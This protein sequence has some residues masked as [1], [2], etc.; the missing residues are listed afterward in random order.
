MKIIDLGLSQ[1]V[2]KH[3]RLK[4]ERG[5]IYYLAPEMIKQNYDHKVDIW[6]A[7]V[8]FYILVTGK[9]PFDGAV[10]APNGNV[11]LDSKQIKQKILEGR[12]NYKRRAFTLVNPG[13]LEIIQKMLTYDPEL[14]PEAREILKHPYFQKKINPQVR[15][16]GS[17]IC[18]V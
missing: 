8:I 18:L 13:V 7:G 2:G 9:P 10:K 1:I 14:R 16:K 17:W 6:S 3:T 11:V 15:E 12:V 5:S 4:K